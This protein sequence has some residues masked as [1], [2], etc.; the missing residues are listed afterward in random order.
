MTIDW[1]NIDRRIIYI[2]VIIA[3]SIPIATGYTL[4]PA[5]LKAAGNVYD[6]IAKVE[7]KKGQIVYIAL[8]FG[9]NTKA[10]NE[11]QAEVMIEHLMRKRIPFA[12]FSLY[13]QAQN[14]LDSIPKRVSARLNKEAGKEDWKYG[15]DWVNLG[16]R[17]GQDIFVQSIPKAE[18][19]VEFFKKD[20]LGN[21]L[22]EMEAFKYSKKFEDIIMLGQFTG[23]VGMLDIYIQYFQKK[24]YVPPIMHGCT[25]IT[26]PEAYNFLDSGQLKGLFEGL[27]GAA[28]YSELLKE[29]YPQRL[30]D[31]AALMNTALGLGHLLII[32]LVILGNLFAFI[33]FKKN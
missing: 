8:D 7:P 33:S 27:A 32:A 18:N 20:A 30:K 3:L 21:S 15:K 11:S 19:L 12:L 13:P 6:Y 10:E 16:Y 31:T 14:F 1:Q 2:L 26:I 5:K 9:P 4:K 23:L 29:G 22:S 25:S 17:A 28:W 24:G